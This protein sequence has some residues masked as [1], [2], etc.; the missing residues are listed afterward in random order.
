[1]SGSWSFTAMAYIRQ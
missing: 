1:M